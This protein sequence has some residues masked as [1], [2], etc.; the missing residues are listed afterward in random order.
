MHQ[1]VPGPQAPERGGLHLLG[2]AG[3]FGQ[4][5]NWNAVAGAD[6]MQKEIA[7]WMN[8]LV[9][10]SGGNDKCAAVNHRPSGRGRDGAYV[11][12]AAPDLVETLFTI[13]HIVS[14]RAP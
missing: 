11:A 4:G 5:L 1:A 2:S 6:V 9:A 3:K 10:E 13:A 12:G 7:E 14:D 8:D